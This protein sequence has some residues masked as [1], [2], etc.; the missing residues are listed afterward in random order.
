[1]D[2][3]KGVFKKMAAGALSFTMLCGMITPAFAAENNEVEHVDAKQRIVYLDEKINGL[4]D[5]KIELENILATKADKTKVDTDTADA[6]KIFKHWETF[7]LSKKSEWVYEN[8]Y[9]TSKA[10]EDWETGFIDKSKGNVA[11]VSIDGVLEA[12]EYCQPMGYII[13]MKPQEKDK[14]RYNC[15]MLWVSGWTGYDGKN[16][17]SLDGNKRKVSEPKRSIA[18]FKIEGMFYDSADWNKVTGTKGFL[19][20]PI[21]QKMYDGKKVLGDWSGTEF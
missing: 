13:R 3:G 19:C 18:L 5:K 15:Y 1:M 2:K 9:L 17:Y 11:D 16:I 14:R 21:C 6:A 20:A 10:N 7:P 12:Q 4:K 8:G